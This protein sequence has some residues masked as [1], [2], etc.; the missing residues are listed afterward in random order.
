MWYDYY[1]FIPRIPL[2]NELPPTIFYLLNSYCNG[3]K[4]EF[5]N[6]DYVKPSD[7]AKEGKGI[8]FDFVYPI[9]RN[10]NKDIFEELILNKFMMRRIG[11]ET[12]TAF[13]IALNV[14]LN[15]IMPKYNKLFDATINWDIFNDGEN[16][17]RN[18]SETRS[19]TNTNNSTST[20]NDSTS[21]NNA[22]TSDRRY[23]NMPQNLIEDV[24]SGSYMTDYNYDTD[25]SNISTTSNISSSNNN[26]INN[27]GNTNIS[28]IINRSPSD[29]F[30]LYKD[31]LEMQDNIYSMI[32]KDLSVLFYALV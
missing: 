13:K 19:D 5:L 4:D 12:L 26:T 9:S 1:P 31:M 30:K 22:S 18:Y 27:N 6:E 10:I 3:D 32:F 11:Y 29:K 14:K 23:S 2:T 25:S 28:E 8:I 17:T 20:S 16:Y 21:T 7:L 15:E 24:K